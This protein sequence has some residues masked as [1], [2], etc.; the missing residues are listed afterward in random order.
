ANYCGVTRE[1]ISRKLSKFES[2]K[3]ISVRGN[4][5]IIITELEK[6][7]ELSE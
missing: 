4:K 3:L 2:D 7:R 6:L 5:I 1:T